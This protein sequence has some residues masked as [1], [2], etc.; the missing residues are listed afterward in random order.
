MS[1]TADQTVIQDYLH[2]LQ[3][4]R[5]YSAHT[6]SNYQRDLM[7]LVALASDQNSLAKLTHFEIRRYTSKLHALGLSA[8][9]IARK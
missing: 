3:I 4:Q 7:Q 6:I 5:Q 2:Y 9:T 8:S 1:N